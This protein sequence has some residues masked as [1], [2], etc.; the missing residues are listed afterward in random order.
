MVFS[1]DKKNNQKCLF[2]PVSS[3]EEQSKIVGKSC[4]MFMN[5]QVGLVFNKLKSNEEHRRGCHF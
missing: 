5:E 3:G 2:T 4:V 1:L